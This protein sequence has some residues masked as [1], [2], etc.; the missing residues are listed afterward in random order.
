MKLSVDKIQNVYFLGI[1]GIGMS[2]LARYFLFKGKKVAGYDR[3]ASDL[4]RELEKEGIQIHYDENLNAIPADFSKENTLVVLTPAVPGEHSELI[5]FQKEGYE[6]CKRSKILGLITDPLKCIA[7]SGTHGKTSTSTMMAHILKNSGVDCAAFLGGISKNYDTNLLLPQNN[8]EWAVAEADEYD[9]SFLQLHPTLA[10]VTSI[11]ADHLDIY[12]THEAIINSFREFVSQVREGGA[13]VVKKGLP[14]SAN[15]NLSAQFYSYALEDD[16]DF[17]G[18]NVHHQNQAYHFDLKTPW[19]ILKDLV[20]GYPGRMNVENAVGA[21]ALALIA[22]VEEEGLRNA[23]ATFGGVKRRFE[24]HVKTENL[25]FIDDYAHHP[26]E[27][28]ATITSVKDLYRG[29]KVTGIFQPHLFSRTKDF[30]DEFAESLSLLDEL[31]LLDIYPAREEPIPGVTSKLIFDKVKCPEKT[32][33]TKDELLGILKDKK[34]EVLL[35][36]GAGDID[37]FVDPITD[38]M[39]KRLV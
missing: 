5:Y 25:V 30:A 39:S 19:G 37:R 29:K 12:G 27:L 18:F 24:H 28:K 21:S 36:L 17:T 2:A 38:L 35:T 4:T 32:L 15:D 22:G 33:C 13:F 34:L 20:L 9:R 1:G 16:A 10:L 31:I 11:D 6:V 23:L 26:M 7:I 3:T 8:S 14:L